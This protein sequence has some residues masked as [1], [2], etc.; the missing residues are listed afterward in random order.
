MRVRV[1]PVYLCGTAWC[2]RMLIPRSPLAAAIMFRIS[3]PFPLSFPSPFLPL[4]FPSPSPLLP[5]LSVFSILFSLWF[6]SFHLCVCETYLSDSA[7][8][9]SSF[10]I[11]YVLPFNSPRFPS[12]TLRAPSIFLSCPLHVPFSSSP[13]CTSISSPSIGHPIV[14]QSYYMLVYYLWFL[15]E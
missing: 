11:H 4:S 6:S 14:H 7:R 3:L 13:T 8:N 2:F 12:W 10:I 15:A 5:F 1:I 9:Q